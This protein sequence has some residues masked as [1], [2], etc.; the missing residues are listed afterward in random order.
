[1][2]CA[3]AVAVALGEERVKK[4]IVVKKVNLWSVRW[5][6]WWFVGKEGQVGKVTSPARATGVRAD[7]DRA[8]SDAEMTAETESLASPSAGN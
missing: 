2:Q 3:V 5:A 6:R 7:P 1:M 4:P 8:H